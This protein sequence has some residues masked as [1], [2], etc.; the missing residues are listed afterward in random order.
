MVS[1]K[2]V[3]EVFAKPEKNPE[4]EKE[5]LKN[6]VMIYG[7]IF[8]V[9][10]LFVIF[11]PSGKGFK[12]GFGTYYTLDNV[13]S[14]FDK[15]TN[16]YNFEL[17]KATEEEDYVM[18]YYIDDN[19]IMY[20]GNVFGD[21]LYL[22]YNGKNYTLVNDTITE[23]PSITYL[24]PIEEYH[25]DLELIKNLLNK[26]TLKYESNVKYTCSLKVNDYI[27]L[28]N[29]KYGTTYVGNDN[30]F[31]ASIVFYNDVADKITID[32]TEIDK[33][34]VNSTR[35]IVTY[36]IEFKSIGDNDFSGYKNYM[37]NLN[38]ENNN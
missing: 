30:P 33:I 6:Q 8:L 15:I 13:N 18:K 32:Y 7:A 16:N 20:E 28:Y 10:A 1:I 29:E 3:K 23:V 22:T 36:T 14:L 5:K 27:S 25:Y 12:D 4:E 9:F 17:T 35:N 31:E 34:L 26:C 11:S 37:D 2:D 38:T 24:E 19:M 21:S